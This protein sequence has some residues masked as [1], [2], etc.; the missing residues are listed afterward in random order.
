[1]IVKVDVKFNDIYKLLERTSKIQRNLSQQVLADSN[2]FIP[3]D[4]GELE[5]SSLIHSDLE[6]GK[7]IWNT[8]Y[9]ARLY[10]NPQYNF[11]T[12]VNPNASGLWFEVAK[13]NNMDSWTKFVA[14]DLGL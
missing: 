9:A 11:S 1:M 14:K 3:K 5:Q 6:A 12:D 10:W 13:Q 7:L 4:T 8:P 2:F